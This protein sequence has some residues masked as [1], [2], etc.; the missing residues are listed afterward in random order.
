VVDPVQLRLVDV[1]V[2]LLAQGARGREVVAERLLHDDA[3]VF[4]QPGGREPGDDGAEQE[5]RDLEVEHGGARAADRGRHSLERARIPEVALHVGEPTREAVERG[6]VERLASGGDRAAGPPAE[7]VDRPVV[8]GYADDRAVEQTALL[9]PVQGPEGH[10][11]RE[12]AGDAEGDE[13]IGR[14]IPVT[15]VGGRTRW[16]IVVAILWSS[17]LAFRVRR[18]RKSMVRR[19]PSPQPDEIPRPAPP[20]GAG[21]GSRRPSSCRGL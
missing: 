18:V 1:P 16:L 13:H 12:V 4:G 14:A 7:I 8:D 17:L 9:E 3:G 15:A 11:L 2:D 21:D 6:L 19:A 20:Y 5:G 10:H